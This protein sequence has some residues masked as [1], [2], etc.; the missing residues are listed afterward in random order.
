MLNEWMHKSVRE[1]VNEWVTSL[2]NW[3]TANAGEKSERNICLRMELSF[4][5]D[6]RHSQG[7]SRCWQQATLV[8]KPSDFLIWAL[9]SLH[10]ICFLPV[11]HLQRLTDSGFWVE[12]VLPPA[13]KECSL[14]FQIVGGGGVG[15]QKN[16]SL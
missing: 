6:T 15:K 1:Q 11:P 10:G 16:S 5:A 9:S 8:G 4:S 13:S 12:F 14:F 7:L 3:N 2:I